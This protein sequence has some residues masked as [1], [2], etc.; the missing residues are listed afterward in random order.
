MPPTVLALPNDFLET[1]VPPLPECLKNLPGSRAAE[2][3]YDQFWIA[4]RGGKP[5]ADLR[6][7]PGTM[8][9]G[10]YTSLTFDLYGGS[11][12]AFSMALSL[13][14]EFIAKGYPIGM[15]DGVHE[16]KPV[17]ELG[18]DFA[19]LIV[20]QLREYQMAAPM[21]KEEEDALRLETVD[22]DRGN[23]LTGCFAVLVRLVT[24]IAGLAHFYIKG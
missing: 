16:G 24:I 2:L 8:S 7:D 4:L 23:P 17:T 21:T 1:A 14:L 22:F 15:I 20:D 13:T 11:E 5:F 10:K 19:K 12:E 18:F 6:S 3:I 9:I